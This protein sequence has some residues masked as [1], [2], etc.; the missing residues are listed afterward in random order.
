M[1]NNIRLGTYDSE[2]QL[3]D[4]GAITTSAAAQ[5]DD[6][7]KEIDVGDARMDAR[8]IV[9]VTAITNGTGETFQ[10]KIQGSD[11]EFDSDIVDLGILNL[12]PAAGMVGDTAVGTGQHEI[13]FHNCPEG[14]IKSHIRAYT[15]VNNPSPAN[16]PVASINYTAH[17]V[18]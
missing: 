2:T 9:N 3:K 4:A 7:A 14:A 5:V 12:G 15:V 13:K 10:V 11:D 16:S 1:S 18:V 17:L 6:S 8:A